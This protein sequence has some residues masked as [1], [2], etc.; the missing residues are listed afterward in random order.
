MQRVTKY[1][2]MHHRLKSGL[3]SKQSL[4]TS[5]MYVSQKTTAP[6]QSFKD[7]IPSLL[8]REGAHSFSQGEVGQW[9]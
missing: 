1:H 8:S 3:I 4:Q 9:F 6:N 5:S 7:S 2:H